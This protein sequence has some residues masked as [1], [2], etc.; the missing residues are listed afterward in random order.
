[1]T[2]ITLPKGSLITLNGIVL[3]EH[4]RSTFDI[5]P[6]DIKYDNR[7]V[8]GTMRRYF[9]ASKGTYNVSWTMLPALDSQTLDGK[10]GRNTLKSLYDNNMGTSITLQYYEVNSSNNQTFVSKTVFIESYSET[11]VKRWG[12]QLWDTKLS[13][14]EV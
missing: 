3:S 2:T 6:N 11:L 8:T 13:L 5:T 9:V 12:M 4:G 10:A 7:T 1:M 14:V